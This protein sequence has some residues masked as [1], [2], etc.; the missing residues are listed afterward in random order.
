[1]KKDLFNIKSM[2]TPVSV[3]SLLLVNWNHCYS[4]GASNLYGKFINKKKILIFRYVSQLCFSIFLCPNDKFCFVW[5]L[6]IINWK[7]SL[8]D[9][10]SMVQPPNKVERIATILVMIFWNFYKV[11]IQ[12]WFAIGK[13]DLDIYCKNIYILSWVTSC[14]TSWNFRILSNKEIL[15][16]LEDD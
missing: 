1:M 8:N 6:L 2:W 4:P 3:S 13:T 12:V 7:L 9:E 15:E 5:I 10:Y 11:L 14:Q 16:N